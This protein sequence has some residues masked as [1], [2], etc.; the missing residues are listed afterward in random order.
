MD[1][2]SIDWTS[3][4]SALGFPIVMCGLLFW[5]LRDT[6]KR[7]KDEAKARE[8]KLME[9]QASTISTLN[10]VGESIERS[11]EINRELSETNRLLVEKLE[12]KLVG[13]DANVNKILDKLD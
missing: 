7:D 10:K 2:T 12:D 13:R 9:N 3:L 11:D 1:L 5:V 8:D 4:V 6:I